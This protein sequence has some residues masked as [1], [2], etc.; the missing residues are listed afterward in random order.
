MGTDNGLVV[1]CDASGT[2]RRRIFD[3]GGSVPGARP[4][5][6]KVSAI[7]VI[8]TDVFV[9]FNESCGD[10]HATG[11]KGKL[12]KFNFAPDALPSFL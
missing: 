7:A 12:V 9:A 1:V 5:S 10:K 6:L 3:A 8:G 4:N 11:F 2:Q